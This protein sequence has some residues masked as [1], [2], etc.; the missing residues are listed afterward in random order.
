[1]IL[2]CVSASGKHLVP[3][4]V[5]SQ[6]PPALQD[7][8]KWHGIEFGRHLI[9]KESQ[10]AYVNG[11]TFAEYVKSVFIPYVTKVRRERGIRV[12]EA[13]LLMDN[14]PNHITKEVIDMLTAARVR[15]VTFAPHTT[16]I[17]QLL[18]LTL[19]GSFK[20]VAKYELP[21][22]DVNSAS[23]FIYRVYMDFKR[24]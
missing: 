13:V 21:F 5:T 2:I 3:Y 23:R 1:M 11:K 9:I 22:T 12:E 4:L 24:L 16:H 6:D 17:F 8:L 18:E 19:F 20:R 15:V 14:Y 10:K 7:D